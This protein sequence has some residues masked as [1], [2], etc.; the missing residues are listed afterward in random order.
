M[1]TLE[2]IK[3]FVINVENE[4]WKL[5]TVFDLIESMPI[6]Q[7][8]IFLNTPAKVD[9]LKGKLS[10]AGFTVVFTHGDMDQQERD[11]IIKEFQM[12]SRRVLITTDDLLALGI[13]A[14]QIQL[15]VNYDIPEKRENY[16]H[17]IGRVVINFATDDTVR[18]L[19]DIETYYNTRIGEMP[20][21]VADLI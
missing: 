18:I 17:R 4:K 12:G 8:V 11:V 6:N 21:N 3:Q 14:K 16:I 19:R 5:E 20:D 15:A 7:A 10:E 2:G 1:A 9:L 13:D